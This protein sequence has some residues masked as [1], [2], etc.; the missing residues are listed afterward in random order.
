MV[1]RQVGWP[2]CL[3]ILVHILKQKFVVE[4]A[5]LLKELYHYVYIHIKQM[6][7]MTSLLQCYMKES[8]GGDY[9]KQDLETSR[10]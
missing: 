9:R 5:D 8:V 7:D 10:R 1:L 6:H 4:A 2:K 3:E